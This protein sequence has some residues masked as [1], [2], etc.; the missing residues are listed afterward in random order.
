MAQDILLGLIS[1]VIYALFAVAIS[2]LY[3]GT[4]SIN[5]ALG[6]VGTFSLFILWWLSTEQGLP[7]LFGLLGALVAGV[8]LTL[9][10]ERF[11]IRRLAR[12]DRTTIAV[13][14]IGLLTLLLSVEGK[15]WG[16]SPRR[17]EA[18]IGGRGIR[19]LDVNVLPSML[20]SF[21]AVGIA[22]AALTVVLRRTDFGLGVLAAAQD[23]DATRLVGVPVNR[24][25]MFVWGLGA[26]LATIAAYLS[27]TALAGI[28][29]PGQATE[30][31]V[32]GLIGAV[33]GGLDSIKGAVAGALAVGVAQRLVEVHITFIDLPNLTVLFLSITVIVTLLVRPTGLFAAVRT[34]G[35]A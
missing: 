31:Y 24:V 16:G 15:I 18:L 25:S 27:T 11:V 9:A 33:I 4:R 29:V 23:T 34:R 6:E 22:V 7:L 12:S 13:A 32:F 19:I 8:G 10:F 17:I 28:V 14:T 20:L 1:G 35:A 26:V 30:L 3:R 21:V 2:V 5:F